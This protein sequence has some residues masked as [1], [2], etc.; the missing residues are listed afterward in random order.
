VALAIVSK[1]Y[2][3]IFRNDSINEARYSGI[4]HGMAYAI[5]IY[6][7]ILVG[8]ALWSRRESHTLSGYF[9]AGKKLPPWVVA[10]STNATGESGWLLLGL[11]GMGYAAGAQAFWVVAGEV[12]GI[13]LAWLLMSLRH[14]WLED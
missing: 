9:I 4:N 2:P 6:L 5:A 14:K 8:L 7:I 11:T 12:V 1:K 10:F 13:A 3:M